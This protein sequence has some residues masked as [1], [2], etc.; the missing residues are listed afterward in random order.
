[1]VLIRML[2]LFMNY[3]TKHIGP[4]YSF[5]SYNSNFWWLTI[6][7]GSWGEQW[8]S[9]QGAFPFHFSANV[10]ILTTSTF[11][12]PI[13]FVNWFFPFCNHLYC[14]PRV[15]K[16]PDPGIKLNISFLLWFFLSNFS[17]P[18][19]D[20]LASFFC[21]ARCC[22]ILFTPSTFYNLPKLWTC[23]WLFPSFVPFTPRGWTWTSRNVILN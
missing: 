12:N 13:L 19:S 1:M 11:N 23:I 20:S 18:F 16:H 7:T 6:W 14:H 8:C 2:I 17:K 4:I 5:F 3:S 22:F 21:A 10:F 15:W 9:A